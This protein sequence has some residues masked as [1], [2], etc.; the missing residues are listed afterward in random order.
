MSFDRLP[1]VFD[2]N[3]L[4]SAAILPK[5]VSAIAFMY[6]CLNFEIIQSDATWEE[7]LNVVARNRFRRYLSD[8]ERNDFIERVTKVSRFI[9]SRSIITDCPDPKDN[10]F[11]SLAIDAGVSLIISGD[12][13]LHDMH[14]YRGITIYSPS[15]F[16]AGKR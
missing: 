13:D 14:P 15:E 8:E 9:E 10:K 5:S 1:I 16:L 7:F 11:L 4:I 12:T 3:A 6:A 2:T